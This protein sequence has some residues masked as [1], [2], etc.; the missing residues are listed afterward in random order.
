MI[1]VR[2]SKFKYNNNSQDYE[3]EEYASNSENDEL[4]KY[5]PFI[6]FNKVVIKAHDIINDNEEEKLLPHSISKLEKEIDFYYIY[7]V[8]DY[9]RY[10]DNY[11]PE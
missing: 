6:A 4:A 9:Q 2:Y 5:H 11:I 10:I 3:I 7:F 1:E 8:Q